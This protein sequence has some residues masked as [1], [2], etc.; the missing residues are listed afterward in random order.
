[1]IELVAGL[2]CLVLNAAENRPEE[3]EVRLPVWTQ[4]YHRQASTQQMSVLPVPEV[5][6]GRHGQGRFVT[7]LRSYVPHERKHLEVEEV[8]IRAALPLEDARPSPTS[9]SLL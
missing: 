9:R 5:S 1:V 6:V 2:G 3:L 8:K 4:L 7:Q